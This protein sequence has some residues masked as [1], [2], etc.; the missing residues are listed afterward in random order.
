MKQLLTIPNLLSLSR[1]PLAF[2]FLQENPLYRLIAILIALVSD[3][4]DGYLSRRY[5]YSTRWGA[6]IDPAADKFFVI[7]ALLVL[8]GEGKIS[9][10]E[11][12]AMLSRDVSVMLFG[13]YLFF[14]DRLFRHRVRAI[15]C[16]KISTVLQFMVLLGLT[17][18]IEIPSPLYLSFVILGVLALFELYLRLPQWRINRSK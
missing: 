18:G 8:I 12:L 6:I 7:F 9:S 4:L 15:W 2:T 16:G 10:L 17:A 1:I 5:R 14:K 11:I 13:F 3:G